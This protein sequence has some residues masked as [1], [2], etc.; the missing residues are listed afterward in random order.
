[1]EVWKPIR[2]YEE[3]YEVSNL[4]RVRSKDRYTPTWNGRV[5]KKGVL[6]T[7]KEDKDGYFKVWLSKNSKK[8]PFFV[9]RLVAEAFIDNPDNLPVV[10]HID[11]DKKNNRVENLEWCTR[12]Q[13]DKH[14][15]KLGIRKP[16]DGGTS[17][18]VL[19]MSPKDGSV[20]IYESISAAARDLG[21]SVQS[22]SMCANGHTKTANGFHWVL[23]DKGVTT[24]RKE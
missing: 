20:K 13:N 2:N 6:K 14:A 17:K 7:L 4:G 16:T 3:S 11:G 1:M 5:F 22:I 15:F 12:S 10:N 9:H 8:K 23:I 18:R 24:I 21:V 19:R